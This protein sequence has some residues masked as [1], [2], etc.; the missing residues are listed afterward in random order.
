M[1]DDLGQTPG[2]VVSRPSS[3]GLRAW[4]LL[5]AWTLADEAEQSSFCEL[6]APCFC[7]PTVIP[8]EF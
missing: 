8:S 3:A 2:P 4:A 7:H 5:F 1:A 6:I